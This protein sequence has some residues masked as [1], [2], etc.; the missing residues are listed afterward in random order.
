VN[1]EETI[2]LKFEDE[3]EFDSVVEEIY[4]ILHDAYNKTSIEEVKQMLLQFQED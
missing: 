3:Y 2:I 1:Q 4:Y